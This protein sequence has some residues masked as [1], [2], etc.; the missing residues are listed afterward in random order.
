MA[1]IP[2]PSSTGP[3]AP[4]SGLR[5][6][7]TRALLDWMTGAFREKG[8]DAPR[9]C[10]EL[11]VA[12]VIGCERL[13]LYMEAD[14]PASD[15]ERDHLRALVARALRHE[16]VQ[17]LVG[18]AWFFSLPMKVD[19]RVLVPRPSSETIV[20]HL[21][22]TVRAD[23][24]L[25]PGGALV[26]ADVCTGS[27]CLAVAILKNLP[28]ARALA[29]D[30]SPP[31]LEVAHLNA[32]RHGV[33]DRIE[34]LQGDLLSPLESHPA[35]H[36]LHALVSNPPYI[37]DHE[38]AEVPP[39]VKDFEPE[40]ALRAG[41]DGL[42]FVRPLIEQ[43]PDHLR[44]G[45]LLFVEIASSTAASVLELARASPRLTGARIVDDFEG[46]PRVLFARRV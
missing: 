28:G 1:R 41:P 13:R 29:T 19:R 9:L 22:Q 27:G 16:P 4:A 15:L 38:W 36:G 33:F 20:E 8:L 6:W 46:L 43:G 10:A 14:R 11:L 40:L 25:A 17:Y 26:I 37:P 21:L 7:T 39:N 23:P 24:G 45:G 5:H 34:L 35:G 42:A 32:Q 31:A 30:L 2:D 18:E 3:R 44:P 12:H